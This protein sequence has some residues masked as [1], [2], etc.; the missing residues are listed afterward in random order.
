MATEKELE[1]AGKR[2]LELADKCYRQ[3]IYCFTGFLDMAELNVFYRIRRETAHVPCTVFGGNAGC[4]RQMVRFG[5]EEMLGYEVPFPIMCL[6]IVPRSEKFADRL[7]HRDFL[8]ACMNLGIERRTLGDII[9]KDFG[10]YLYCTEEIGPYIMENLNRIRHTSVV[11]RQYTGEADRLQPVLEERSCQVSSERLDA[12][13]AKS[14]GLSREKSTLLFREKK[15]FVNG[16]QQESGS[17]V[18]MKGDAVTVRGYG[19]F[20]YRGLSHMTRKGKC[21]IVV[22]FYV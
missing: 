12:V 5:S 17:Y 15:V 13:I 11:C 21:N 19:K 8:G 9:V 10:A 2:F 6:E 22:A 14:L 18:P 7:T 1:Q 4:E 20:V 16:R 3:N